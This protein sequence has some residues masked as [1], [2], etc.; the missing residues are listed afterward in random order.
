MSTPY[1]HKP[2]HLISHAFL[3]SLTRLDLDLNLSLDLDLDLDLD[4]IKTSPT[5]ATE[6]N[7]YECT[8]TKPSKEHVT[9]DSQSDQKIKRFHSNYAKVKPDHKITN[10]YNIRRIIVSKYRTPICTKPR[11]HKAPYKTGK[12]PLLRNAA[13]LKK[14][15]K[16]R[17]INYTEKEILTKEIKEKI[18]PEL[19]VTPDSKI[20]KKHNIKTYYVRKY[21]KSKHITPYRFYKDEIYIAKKELAADLLALN[22][23]I[24]EEMHKH[25]QITIN[26]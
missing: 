20:A 6:N 9:T 11:P 16:K 10:R 7:E 18:F 1:A 17:K 2:L 23:A 19:G 24:T 3:P 8:Q 15:S 14:Q 26:R 21:R 4:L 12:S 5:I 13:E 22:Q 25:T